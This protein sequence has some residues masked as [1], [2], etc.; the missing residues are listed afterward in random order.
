MSD[1]DVANI[2]HEIWKEWACWPWSALRQIEWSF[3]YP[4]ALS[5]L[6]GD[7]QRYVDTFL[8]VPLITFL[9]LNVGNNH[10]TLVAIDGRPGFKTPC[11]GT[12]WAAV[13]LRSGVDYALSP[14]NFTALSF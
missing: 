12:L 1:V 13:Q 11:S 8:C 2:C 5:A 9:P 3:S 7:L 4:I 6:L 14:P 10:W